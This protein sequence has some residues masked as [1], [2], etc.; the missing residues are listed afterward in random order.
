M[1]EQ[2]VA[3]ELE[4]YL[5][6]Q[7]SKGPLF[8]YIVASGERGSLPHGIASVSYTHLDVYKRQGPERD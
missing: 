1:S 6:R 4:Y 3:L 2:E 7:G 8:R 5:R